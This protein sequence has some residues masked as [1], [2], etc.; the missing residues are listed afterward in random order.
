MSDTINK[1]F[2]VLHAQWNEKGKK[3]ESNLSLFWNLDFIWDKKVAIKYGQLVS[4]PTYVLNQPIKH[5][6]VEVPKY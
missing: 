2:R 1:F 5:K 3:C 6:T 4:T